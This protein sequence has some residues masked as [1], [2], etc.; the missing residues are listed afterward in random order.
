MKKNNIEYSSLCISKSLHEAIRGV[1]ELGGQTEANFIHKSLATSVWWMLQRKAEVVRLKGESI[2]E[3]FKLLKH[4][5]TMKKEGK[6]TI[7]RCAGNSQQIG[8]MAEAQAEMQKWLKDKKDWDSHANDPFALFLKNIGYENTWDM[9]RWEKDFALQEEG[10]TFDEREKLLTEEGRKYREKRGYL[11]SEIPFDPAFGIQAS[12]IPEILSESETISKLGE[13]IWRGSF[14]LID[15]VLL[16]VL[17]GVGKKKV[18]KWIGKKRIEKISNI[19][20]VRLR[21][22]IDKLI[23]RID[24]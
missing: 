17:W 20:K 22:S 5:W 1:S 21:K 12:L 13:V 18:R 8:I 19:C 4:H 7:L 10:I 14:S 16:L 15:V 6:I 9:R 23:D 3:D 2:A 24:K 11:E